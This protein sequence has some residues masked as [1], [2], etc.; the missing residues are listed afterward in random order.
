MKN[1]IAILSVI[2]VIILVV[3][4]IALVLLNNKSSDKT[5]NITS[6]STSNSNGKL[7]VTDV[8]IK[9]M[10]FSPKT[11]TI[12]AG[13]VVTWENNDTVL[14]TVTANNGEFT[15][16]NLESGE[17][18]SFTFNTS[19]TYTYKCTLHSGMSGTIIVE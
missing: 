14:H 11:I 12:K 2:A 5:G 3:V 10:A 18:F 8:K 17:T 7:V 13:S 1:N 6:D 16:E 9:N 4:A 19:G 15:S